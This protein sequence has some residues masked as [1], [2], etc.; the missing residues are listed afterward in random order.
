[1]VASDEAERVEAIISDLLGRE[2]PEEKVAEEYSISQKIR[3]VME[4]VIFG[5]FIPGRRRRRQPP[6]S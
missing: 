1:M 4:T 6:G 5:W 3:M 2:L